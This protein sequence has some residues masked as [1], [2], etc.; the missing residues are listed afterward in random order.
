[1]IASEKEHYEFKHKFGQYYHGNSL[2]IYH[3]NR[4]N[5]VVDEIHKCLEINNFELM[6]KTDTFKKKLCNDT[7]QEF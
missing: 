7:S 5:C 4:K 1:L 3:Y 6:T 2:Q